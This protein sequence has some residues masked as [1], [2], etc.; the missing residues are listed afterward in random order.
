MQAD[1]NSACILDLSQ[2]GAVAP[3]KGG[4]GQLDAVRGSQLPVYMLQVDLVVSSQLARAMETAKPIAELQALAGNPKPQIRSEELLIDRDWGTFQGK[5]V[6]EVP[7]R[8]AYAN[9]FAVLRLHI[10]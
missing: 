1:F 5:L 7:V 8:S 10:R 2:L 3:V 4:S 6:Q 9:T